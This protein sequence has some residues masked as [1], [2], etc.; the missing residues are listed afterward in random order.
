MEES[1]FPSWDEMM[2]KDPVHLT[3]VGHAKLANELVRMAKGPDAVFSGGMRAHECED[4]RPAPI[5]GGRK[6][7]IYNSASERWPWRRPRRPGQLY[8]RPWRRPRRG[9]RK[10][11]ALRKIRRRIW[12]P[13]GRLRQ[14]EKVK[15]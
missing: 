3:G 6:Q 1:E 7:W 15:L 4:D 10:R 5:I 12:L 9:G 8:R 2:G 14:Q 13:A 11:G